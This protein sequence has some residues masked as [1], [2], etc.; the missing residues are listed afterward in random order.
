MFIGHA[1]KVL[2][3][4]GMVD[5][6]WVKAIN[7]RFQCPV[8]PLKPLTVLLKMSIPENKNYLTLQ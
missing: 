1:A 6:W 5:G 3:R 4:M 8:A 2:M 7:N